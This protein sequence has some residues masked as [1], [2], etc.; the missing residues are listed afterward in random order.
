MESFKPFADKLPEGMLL[1]TSQGEILSANRAACRL[2]Q[3]T[4]SELVHRNLSLI[5]D[6]TQV[7]VVNRLRPC[8]RSRTPVKVAIKFNAKPKSKELSIQATGFLFTPATESVSAQV[9][10]RLHQ[11]VSSNSQFAT[12]K[13]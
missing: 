9:L 12:L 11:N 8:S 7:E 5:T 6:S 13:Q 10:L 4:H 3:R 2:L 1:L